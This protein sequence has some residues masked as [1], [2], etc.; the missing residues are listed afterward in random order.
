MLKHIDCRLPPGYP[1]P[2]Y[3]LG[4][5]NSARLDSATP[6]QVCFSSDALSQSWIHFGRC[7]PKQKC[8]LQHHH[9]HIPTP[10]PVPASPQILGS[11]A[12]NLA[13]D[14]AS[15]FIPTPHKPFAVPLCA[16]EALPP[17]P[18][19]PAQAPH[20]TLLWLFLFLVRRCQESPEAEALR[21]SLP[22][23]SRR[24]NSSFHECESQ[25]PSCHRADE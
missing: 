14:K 23:R 3:S 9:S 10:I 25:R 19:P 24:R 1:P 7:H 13:P 21:D 2:K 16:L 22:C 4:T 11:C 6:S 15:T 17:S 12:L 5:S 8:G 18:A 20:L